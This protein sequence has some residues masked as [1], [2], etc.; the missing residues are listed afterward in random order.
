ML[1]LNHNRKLSRKRQSTGLSYLTISKTTL[2]QRCWEKLANSMVHAPKAWVRS[3]R[4]TLRFLMK[5]AAKNKSTS[6]VPRWCRWRIS[7]PST[8]PWRLSRH[9]LKPQKK[10]VRVNGQTRA[11]ASASITLTGQKQLCKLSYSMTK[12]LKRRWVSCAIAPLLL[13]R[14]TNSTHKTSKTPQCRES[15]KHAKR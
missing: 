14:S 15:S 10:T 3:Y 11:I 9:S 7:R 12:A 6:L 4:A 5:S 1:M 2:H 8:L 13:A